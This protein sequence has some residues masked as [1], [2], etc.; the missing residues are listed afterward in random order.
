MTWKNR[1]TRSGDGFREGSTHPTGCGL[2]NEGQNLTI[3]VI[4][5]VIEIVLDRLGNISISIEI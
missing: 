1:T 5:V 4:S 3:F 2:R